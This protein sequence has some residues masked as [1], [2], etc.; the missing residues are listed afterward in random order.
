MKHEA[1]AGM[2][3]VV[4]PELLDLNWNRCCDE[5]DCFGDYSAQLAAIGLFYDYYRVEC[6]SRVLET[7]TV[8]S[9]S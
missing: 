3:M 5:R 9:V 2:A 6:L 8:T 1:L 4:S 7:W